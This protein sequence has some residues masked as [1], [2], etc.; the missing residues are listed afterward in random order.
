[1]KNTIVFRLHEAVALHS[2]SEAFS[3]ENEEDSSVID[4]FFSLFTFSALSFL[5]VK[6]FSTNFVEREFRTKGQ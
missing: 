5:E 1:M 2:F 3:A 4:Y 6:S